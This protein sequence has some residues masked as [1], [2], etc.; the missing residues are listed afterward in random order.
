MLHCLKSPS[1]DVGDLMSLETSFTDSA[2]NGSLSRPTTTLTFESECSTAV[3]AANRHRH[4]TDISGGPS[5]QLLVGRP[6]E[7]QGKLADSVTAQPAS[8]LAGLDQNVVPTARP[9]MVRCL[10][11]ISADVGLR[12]RV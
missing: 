7:N 5:E 3:A 4:S 8:L 1:H 12:A 10:C 6:A 2:D 9:I 11:P